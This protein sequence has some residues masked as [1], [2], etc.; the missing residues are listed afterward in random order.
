MIVYFTSI[1]SNRWWGFGGRDYESPNAPCTLFLLDSPPV[2]F[3]SLW[4]LNI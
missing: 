1:C 3:A 2:N 4:G